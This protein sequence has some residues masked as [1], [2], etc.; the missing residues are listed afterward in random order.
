M[1]GVLVTFRY[2]NQFNEAQ[3]RQVPQGCAHSIW[4]MSNTRAR[5]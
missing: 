3:V 2:G 5:S 1:L 4:T